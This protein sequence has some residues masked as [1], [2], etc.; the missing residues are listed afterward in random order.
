MY[1]AALFQDKQAAMEIANEIHAY[2]WHVDTRVIT[3]WVVA[4][5]V[6]MDC[7]HVLVEA[8]RCNKPV[9]LLDRAAV[10]AVGRKVPDTWV[11]SMIAGTSLADL[12]LD[13]SMKLHNT[14]DLVDQLQDD[15]RRLEKQNKQLTFVLDH[16]LDKINNVAGTKGLAFDHA[17]EEVRSQL[18]ECREKLL[19][20]VQ[21]AELANVTGTCYVAVTGNVADGFAFTGPWDCAEKANEEMDKTGLSFDIISVHAPE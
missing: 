17:L 2:C 4:S 14:M 9:Y 19:D 7:K 21:V 1:I 11:K 16:R 10:D 20:S 3:A 12:M 18:A 6:T 13:H 15:V 8:E 5:P